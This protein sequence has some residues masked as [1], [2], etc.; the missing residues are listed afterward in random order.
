[1]IYNISN[2]II[3]LSRNRIKDK[4]KINKRSLSVINNLKKIADKKQIEIKL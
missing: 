4:F 1:M 2:R 3:N